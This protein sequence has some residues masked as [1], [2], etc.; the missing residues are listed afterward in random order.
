[1]GRKAQ[2]RHS[3]LS[4]IEPHAAGIDIGATSHFVA[5]PPDQCEE[6][7]QEFQCH[8]SDLHRGAQWLKSH[9]IKT[10]AMESTGIY[11][12]P[13]YNQMWCISGTELR[14]RL[15]GNDGFAVFEN[16]TVHHI[17]KLLVASETL[18]PYLS[19]QNELM[20]HR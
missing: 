6:P 17:S 7:V 3:Q 19:R 5:V 1:M 13:S 4:V 11:W 16:H 9:G 14:F 15:L 10:V 2:T 8:T 20:R 18:P 12:L